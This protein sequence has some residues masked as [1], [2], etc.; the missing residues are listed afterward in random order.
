MR[1]LLDKSCDSAQFKQFRNELL[2]YAQKTSNPYKTRTE[3]V[4]NRYQKQN[5][6]KYI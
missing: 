6:E 3:P 5:P 1:P 4:K 2:F